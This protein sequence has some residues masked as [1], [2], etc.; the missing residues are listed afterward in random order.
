MNFFRNFPLVHVHIQNQTRKDRNTHTDTHTKTH[1]Q[2]HTH[3]Q[4]HTQTSTNTDTHATCL[5]YLHVQLKFDHVSAALQHPHYLYQ[6]L[7]LIRKVMKNTS[8]HL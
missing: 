7:H 5:L 6:E 3:A 1:I 8:G 2:T 4:L